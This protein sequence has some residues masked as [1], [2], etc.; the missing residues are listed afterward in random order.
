V[1]LAVQDSLQRNV[2]AG[3]NV[4]SLC[5]KIAVSV[6]EVAERRVRAFVFNGKK[7]WQEAGARSRLSQD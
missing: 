2:K 7:I 4:L 6:W 3:E 5:R 1:Q